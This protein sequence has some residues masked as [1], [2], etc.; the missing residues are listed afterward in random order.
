V[1]KDRELA[2]SLVPFLDRFEVVVGDKLIEEGK[3]SDDIY[4]ME[5][6]RAA[7]VIET[8][9]EHQVRVATVGRGSIVG[10]MSFYLDKPR[11]AS[12]VAETPVIAWRLSTQS[13]ERLCAASPEAAVAFHR[14]MAG[15]IADRLSSTNQLVRLLAD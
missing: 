13:L 1:V 11:S 14:G 5:E 15:M 2:E 8:D 9:G 7:V 3:P 10:E 4:F 6:G 12:V